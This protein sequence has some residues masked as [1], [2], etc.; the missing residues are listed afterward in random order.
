MIVMQTR[1][2]AVKGIEYCGAEIHQQDTHTFKP[3]CGERSSDGDPL[4]SWVL[5]PRYIEPELTGS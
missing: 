1:F 4:E 3:R 5:R 2:W